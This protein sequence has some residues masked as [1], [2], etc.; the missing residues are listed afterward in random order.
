VHVCTI[1]LVSLVSRTIKCILHGR[2]F[3]KTALPPDSA[4]FRFVVVVD[5][6]SSVGELVTFDASDASDV[7]LALNDGGLSKVNL[8]YTRRSSLRFPEDFF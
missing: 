5:G 1:S 6:A 4:H 2:S 8:V 7:L 3:S